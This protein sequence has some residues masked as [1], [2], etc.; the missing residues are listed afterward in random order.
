MYFCDTKEVTLS[1]QGENGPFRKIVTLL[2]LLLKIVHV[3]ERLIQILAKEIFTLLEIYL[4]N[5][6]SFVR[7]V[8]FR[9][10][11]FQFRKIVEAACIALL[12]SD[13]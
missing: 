9:F 1:P 4:N 13:S 2:E 7:L 5:S 12:P 3:N 10:V 8:S 11:S 6:F